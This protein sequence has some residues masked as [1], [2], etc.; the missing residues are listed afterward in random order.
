MRSITQ[1]YMLEMLDST[2][3]LARLR[4]K[5][6]R[7]MYHSQTGNWPENYP[8][9]LLVCDNAGLERELQNFVAR[10]LNYR[11]LVKP[12]Y[13]TTTL[14]A[15]YGARKANDAIW[16]NVLEPEKLLPL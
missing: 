8:D 1:D 14:R 12:Q 7:F 5:A 6:T 11:G 4:Q 3:S 13:Y 10:T 2:T 9:I 16:S 15:L